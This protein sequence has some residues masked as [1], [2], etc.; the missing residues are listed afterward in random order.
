MGCF[1]AILRGIARIAN[2][3]KQL[4]NPKLKCKECV[5]KTL[6]VRQSTIPNVLGMVISV[7]QGHSSKIRVM[8]LVRLPEVK[9]A[10]SNSV[11]VSNASSIKYFER[12][13]CKNTW[14]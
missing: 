8:K 4:V 13:Y 12:E 6:A 14:F 10:I 1:L 2:N 7:H 3:N 9:T 5:L 11:K